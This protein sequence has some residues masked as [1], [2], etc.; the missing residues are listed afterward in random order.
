M[1][2][3]KTRRKRESGGGHG[4]DESSRSAT[5]QALTETDLHRSAT[6]VL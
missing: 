1:Y 5:P 2:R 4:A 3:D 6:G